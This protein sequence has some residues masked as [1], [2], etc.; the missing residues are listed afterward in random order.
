[1]TP[2]LAPTAE[3][4]LD[5]LRSRLEEAEETLLA[6]R[7]GQVDALV[8][9]GK[10]GEQ[11][12]TLRGAEEPYR[13]IVEQMHEGALTVGRDGIVLYSNQRFAELVGAPLEQV[14]GAYLGSFID[15]NERAAV[16]AALSEVGAAG[17]RREVSLVRRDGRAVPAMLSVR[18]MAVDGVAG[19]CAIVTDL[20]ERKRAEEMAIAERFT[21]SIV[22]QLTDP[23]IV[24]DHGGIITHLNE[25]A[26]R[27]ATGA[28]IGR[29]LGE[30]FPL[31]RGE[32]SGGAEPQPAASFV[33][34]AALAGTPVHNFEASLASQEAG[35]TFLL[36]AGPLLDS[37]GQIVGCIIALT[38]ITLRKRTEEQHRILLAELNHRVK[39]N[40]AIVRSVASQTLSRSTTLE[41]FQRAFDGRLSAL[42]VA[43]NI[44]T[45][46]GWQQADVAEL[47]QQVMSPYF[48]PGADRIAMDG[49]AVRVPP[50]FVLPLAIVFH[51]LATNAA[52]YGA[53]SVQGGRVRIVWEVEITREGVWIKLRWAETGGP[54][55]TPPSREGFGSTLIRR[56][57]TYELDGEAQLDYA[58]TGVTCAI[59]FPLRHN[60]TELLEEAV[61][62]ASP[63]L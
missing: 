7:T 54:T 59:A 29:P 52:K 33:V 58:R 14:V 51:E 22:D 11:V 17:M 19:L 44:L 43:H 5:L 18:L 41:G 60:S 39:N 2:L 46:T 3:Q 13:V 49:P 48:T 8:V 20:T 24:C 30:P 37:R 56:T 47:V 25:A 6:I 31:M 62:T 12:F 16:D 45:R 55:V 53:L 1:L 63:A 50:Q 61:R 23:L 21:R 36:S 15:A 4:E 26:R 27:L 35:A 57:V 32:T 34:A 40:L 9:H 38:D 28:P 10:Q 42:A